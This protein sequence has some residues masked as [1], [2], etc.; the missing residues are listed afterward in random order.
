MAALSVPLAVALILSSFVQPVQASFGSGRLTPCPNSVLAIGNEKIGDLLA[1]LEGAEVGSSFSGEMQ[2]GTEG[3][4]NEGQETADLGLEATDRNPKPSA[5]NERSAEDT[6]GWGTESDGPESNSNNG[7]GQTGLWGTIVE[8]LR[9]FNKLRSE[10][11]ELSLT[12]AREAWEQILSL[13]NEMPEL[14]IGEAK[15]VWLEIRAMR[16]ETPDL[17][18]DQARQA[19]EQVKTLRVEMPALDFEKAQEA[20]EEIRELQIEFPELSFDEAQQVWD[21]IRELQVEVPDLSFDE[22]RDAWGQIGNLRVEMPDLGFEEAKEIREQIRNLQAESPELS[23]E[24]AR[25]AWV[26]IWELQSEFPDLSFDEAQQIWDQIRA[27][28]VEMPDLDSEKVLELWQKIKSLQVDFPDL[29]FNDA[30]EAWK[31]IQAMQIEFPDVNVG[32]A[33]DFLSQLRAVQIGVPEVSEEE[34]RALWVQIQRL[35][36]DASPPDFPELERVLQQM[37]ELRLEVP[38]LDFEEARELWFE[39]QELRGALPELSFEQAKDLWFELRDL[40]DEL[41]AAD[42][43]FGLVVHRA[44][45]FLHGLGFEDTDGDGHLNWPEGTP[46]EGQD[47]NLEVIITDGA[48]IAIAFVPVGGDIVDGVAFLIGKDP[49][50]GECLTQLEQ[51]LVA[52][53]IIP[54]LPLSVKSA[55][56]VGK[57]VDNF[58]PLVRRDLVNFLP[59]LP[60]S[61]RLRL[62]SGLV[63]PRF[64]KFRTIAGEGATTAQELADSMNISKFTSINYRESL[65]RFTGISEEAARGLEA[66]HILPQEFEERFLEHGIETIHDPRLMVWVGRDEHRA[67]SSAYSSAWADF[68]ERTPDATRLQILEEA[69]EL[70]EEYGY[71]V[72]FELAE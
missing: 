56:F 17:D 42:G 58:L 7:Q 34:A 27:L 67:W 16:L 66:H 2:D 1:H 59:N 11:P 70:S 69:Q 71:K 36:E 54:L 68:F 18:Y 48:G 4:A 40:K 13:L 65:R 31:H 8:Y 3:E 25:E 55:R 19:W 46:F 37:Q 9:Q 26:E 22:A 6:V 24:K 72:L 30:R 60:A 20:W 38:S 44:E 52:I 49:Y 21:Q 53:A 50:T 23:F 51:F 14:S 64:K 12:E 63:H 33:Q 45:R 5:E 32:N 41:P 10:M 43:V 57:Q 29:S 28:R 35:S 62:V 15:K 39:L 47:V 61:G